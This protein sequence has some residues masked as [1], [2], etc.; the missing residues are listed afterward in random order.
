MNMVVLIKARSS[1]A[2]L[3]QQQQ[4][5]YP[6]LASAKVKALPSSAPGS[7]PPQSS[8]TVKSAH[9]KPFQSSANNDLVMTNSNTEVSGGSSVS[10]S[11]AAAISPSPCIAGADGA[12]SSAPTVAAIVAA[13]RPIVKPDDKL[14][15]ASPAN[16]KFLLLSAAVSRDLCCEWRHCALLGASLLYRVGKAKTFLTFLWFNIFA[17]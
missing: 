14:K 12:P 2:S 6:P 10:T 1:F 13:S 7:Q 16:G 11:S 3:L 15:A 9:V 8:P 4:Q 5:Q 17:F